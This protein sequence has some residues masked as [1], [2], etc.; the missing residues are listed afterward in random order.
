MGLTIVEYTA[1]RELEWLDVHASVMVDSTAW[2][3]VLHKKPTYAKVVDLIALIDD[4]LVGF[5]TIEINADIISDINPAGFVWE[6]GVYRDFRGR[7]IAMALIDEAHIRMKKQYKINTSIW[8]SQEENAQKFYQYLGME[9]IGRHWQFS[10]KADKTIHEDF[11]KKGFNCWNLRGSCAIDQWE[12]V[13][14]KF[15]II[16]DEDATNPRICIGY[17]YVK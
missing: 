6:F 2:W 11:L 9:E 13:Q 1:E 7:G 5:I 10:I 3:T 12:Q 15:S 8:Y 4:K 14:N 17:K 16:R